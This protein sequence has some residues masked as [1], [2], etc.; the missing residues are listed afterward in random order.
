[1][2]N[3]FP[4]ILLLSL[5]LTGCSQKY[6]IV[7]HAEKAQASD[8]IVMQSPN[9]PPLSEKGRE[10][11][12]MLRNRLANARI[13]YVYSTNTARTIQ[14]ATP[15]AD[16]E[17]LRIDQ[18]GRVDS[19]LLAQ[20][21][22]LKKNTLIVGHSNT[23]DDLVNGLTGMVHLSDLPDTAYDNLFIVKKKGRRLTFFNE[24]FGQPSAK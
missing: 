5:L 7:R 15:F 19:L 24:K 4:Q 6:Y 10:R 13:G 2:L 18:Y 11:A 17:G 23:V 9:D 14:T 3:R 22:S 21:K 1:M 20:L 8:G 12:N 16:A